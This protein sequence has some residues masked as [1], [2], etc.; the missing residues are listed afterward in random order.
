MLKKVSL[1]KRLIFNFSS[2]LLVVISLGII[3]IWSNDI[4]ALSGFTLLLLATIISGY[5]LYSCYKN[6][7][8]VLER[9]GLQLDAL[10]NEEFNSWHLAA[11]NHGRLNQLKTDYERLSRKLVNKRQEYLHNEVFIFDVLNELSLPVLV[12]DHYG[13]AF[14]SNKSFSELIH[15]NTHEIIGKSAAEF[16]IE[17]TKSKWVQQPNSVFTKR[18]EISHHTLLKGGRKFQLLVFFSIEQKLRENEKEVWLRLIRVLN[19]EVRNSLTPIYSMTQSLKEMKLSGE[20]TEQQKMVE[21]NLLNV[22]EKRAQQ[23]LTFVDSYS[24]FSKLAEPVKVVHWCRDISD[25]IQ[26]IF[27]KLNIVCSK[28][29][30]L[31]IDADQLE[32]ALINIVKNAFEASESDSKVTMMWVENNE[33]IGIQVIDSGTGILNSENLFVPFFTTKAEGTGI[34]LV[35]SRE[36]IRNQGGELTLTNRVNQNGAIAII[37]LESTRNNTVRTL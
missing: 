31:N 9:V 10:G 28:N 36:L 29:I 14:T 24:T 19:H 22:I 37:T 33:K 27:P 7:I 18:H 2:L 35:L 3:I 15:L 5:F 4:D 26:T 16:G 23:L 21:S 8:D 20:L 12:L 25:R 32:Q 30:K 34:G 6:I 13:N 17:Y 1:E 11:Y